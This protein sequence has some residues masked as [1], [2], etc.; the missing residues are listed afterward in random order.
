[1]I[2]FGS[3][4]GFF[5]DCR[6]VLLDSE[7]SPALVQGP[8]WRVSSVANSFYALVLAKD[9][10]SEYLCLMQVRKERSD[11]QGACLLI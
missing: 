6:P 5:G 2:L 10:K 8:N 3:S 4:Q 9:P 1:V 11:Q 7:R